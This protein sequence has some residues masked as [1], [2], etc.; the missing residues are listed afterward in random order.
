MML[1]GVLEPRTQ[2]FLALTKLIANLVRTKETV[3][4]HGLAHFCDNFL[5]RRDVKACVSLPIIPSQ[6]TTKGA[7]CRLS[8]RQESRCFF[9][10]SVSAL[11]R[12]LEGFLPEQEGW[13]ASQILTSTMQSV[14]PSQNPQMRMPPRSPES[15][16]A[17]PV[18]RS[19]SSRS[20][21]L[22]QHGLIDGSL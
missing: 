19:L 17:S 5:A 3:R 12:M 6:E 7:K 16:A 22:S 10:F 4:L 18:A 2:R 15:S 11:L 8:S 9:F 13:L 1:V 20:L 14:L 21:L